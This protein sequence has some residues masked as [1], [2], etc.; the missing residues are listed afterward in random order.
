MSLEEKQLGRYRMLKLIGRGG[1]GEVYLADDEQV[2]RQVAA[3]VVQIGEVWESESVT[4]PLRRFLREATTI[5]KL[6]HPNILSLYDYGE[7]EVDHA[8]FAYLITPYRPEGSLVNWLSKRLQKQGIEAPKLTLKQVVH[9]IQQAGKALQYAHDQQIIHQ[10]VKPGNFLI[11]SESDNDEYPD[12]L[13][14]DFGIALLMSATTNTSQN[15][16]GTPTYMAPEQWAG[17]PVFASDQ[18]A[19]AVMAYE[20]LTG[21]PPFHG[22][23]MN[24]MYAHLREQPE[25][26]SKLN[27][28]LSA[29]VDRVLLQALAKK[30]EERFPTVAAFAQALQKALEGV[31]AGTVLYAPRPSFAT[32]SLSEVGQSTQIPP[33]SE[34]VQITQ[35]PAPVSAVIQPV[36]KR[37]KRR[38]LPAIVVVCIVLILFSVSGGLIYYAMAGSWPW[39]ASAVDAQAQS[40]SAASGSTPTLAATATPIPT[41]T[42]SPTAIPTASPSPEATGIPTASQ[43]SVVG[44][45]PTPLPKA[46]PIPTAQ[47]TPTPTPVPTATPTPV[48]P[49]LVVT[50]TAIGIPGDGTNCSTYGPPVTCTIT[51]SEP[52]NAQGGLSWSA[53]TST[54]DNKSTITPSSGT[55]SPGQSITV[56]ITTPLCGGRWSYYFI[57]DGVATAVV[58][59]CG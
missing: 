40:R 45:V 27:P 54:G 15:V 59:S 19:L 7:E 20:L 38:R 21:A 5:A 25:V 26:P 14:A 8:H 53:T 6:D 32:V 58:Y 57:V 1:T 13:L 17:K 29:E 48:K 35:T 12:L 18:Y 23:A 50:P 55:L 52:S 51:L 47:P 34:V 41:S 46:T 22:T 11:R 36:T 56:T 44:A 43:S 49:T 9:L 10:D 42:S 37:F 33:V 24:M 28:Q 4:N 16:C 39:Q 2:S 31:D 3:K 30:A